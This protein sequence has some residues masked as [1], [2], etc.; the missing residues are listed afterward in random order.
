LLLTR[1]IGVSVHLA[2]EPET[3]VIKGA[4]MA[5]EN[6]DVYRKSIR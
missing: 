2:I 5:M 6:L 3:C 4:G 1:E